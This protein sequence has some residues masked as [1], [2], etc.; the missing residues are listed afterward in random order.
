VTLR[1]TTT[2]MHAARASAVFGARPRAFVVDRARS[3]R[4]G[5]MTTTR[6]GIPIHIEYCEK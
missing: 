3:A 4:R 1:R 2:R 5:M 6:A